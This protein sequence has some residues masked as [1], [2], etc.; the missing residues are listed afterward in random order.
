MIYLLTALPGSGKTLFLMEW[1]EKEFPNRAVWYSGIKQLK[2]PWHKLP[3]WEARTSEPGG[4]DPADPRLPPPAV[5]WV[6]VPEGSVVV[7]DECQ[8]TFRP[9]PTGSKV[10]PHVELLENHRHRGID[11]ILITQHPRQIDASVR[12]LVGSHRHLVRVFGSEASI[13]HEWGEICD[14][15]DKSRTDSIRK[16]W[17]FPKRLY[18]LYASSQLHTHKRRFPVKIILMFIAPVVGVMLMGWGIWYAFASV[19]N[20]DKVIEQATGVPAAAAVAAPGDRPGRPRT[21]GRTWAQRRA[22]HLDQLRP[23][24]PGLPHTAEAYAKV[25]EP[26]QAP[27]PAACISTAERCRCYTQ[28]ATLLP[29]VPGDVC[30]QIVAFGYFRSWAREAPGSVYD[31]RSHAPPPP[32]A[33]QEGAYSSTETVPPERAPGTL[34]EATPPPL[35]LRPR[36]RR[37]SQVSSAP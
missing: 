11:I 34:K 23:R 3:S 10:P 8:G 15:P 6:D 7:L 22:A 27:E 21:E 35:T 13:V 1:I 32:P 2:L 29:E 17:P 30:R 4:D 5:D 14:E 9:R 26:H 36:A 25:T 28:Q 18:G 19:M 12:R 24:I 16:T 37:V 20:R 31:S 33:Q